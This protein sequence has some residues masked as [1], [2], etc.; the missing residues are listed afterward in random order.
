MESKASSLFPRSRVSPVLRSPRHTV[1]HGVCKVTELR[2][3]VHEVKALEK[4]MH[5]VQDVKLEVGPRKVSPD[6]V[7][8]ADLK[9]LADE[10]DEEEEDETDQPA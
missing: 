1:V 5:G 9:E 6:Q 7:S 10:D 8:Y 3:L 4:E 2:K